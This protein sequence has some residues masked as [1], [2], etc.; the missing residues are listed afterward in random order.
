MMH[1][2]YGQEYGRGGGL[3]TQHKHSS[4]THL[5]VSVKPLSQAMCS[6]V[7]F[8]SVLAVAS[9]PAVNRNLSENKR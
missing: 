4:H 8:L 3:C 6:A 2:L 7:R 9:A 5:A 1:I